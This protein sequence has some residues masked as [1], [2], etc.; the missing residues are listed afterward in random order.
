MVG[1][2]KIHVHSAESDF[3]E[4]KK[5]DSVAL[6][7]EDFAG[8]TSAHGLG[9]TV[10]ERSK[11]GKIVWLTIFVFAST[12]NLVHLSLL[13]QRYMQYPTQ[14]VTS[15][16]FKNITYNLFNYLYNYTYIHE[17]QY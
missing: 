6:L 2:N 8:N 12:A 11:I 7:L 14:D 4:K 3:P 16:S 17:I 15:V 1:M 9:G 13:I 10:R 5:D